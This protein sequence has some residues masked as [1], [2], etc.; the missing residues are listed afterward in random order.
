MIYSLKFE[1]SWEMP[2]ETIAL[3][4]D[5]TINVRTRAHTQDGVINK[6][7][8]RAAVFV[9]TSTLVASIPAQIGKTIALNVCA[10][11]ISDQ[12]LRYW[13]PHPTGTVS[14]ISNDKT[15]VTYDDRGRVKQIVRD[16]FERQTWSVK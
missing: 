9:A 3:A 8:G 12:L 7:F 6:G 2:A 15:V 14:I 13:L 16:H 11:I 1:L 10:D 4:R 5:V